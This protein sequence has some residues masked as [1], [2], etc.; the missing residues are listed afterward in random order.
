M[1]KKYQK[2][3][4]H[5]GGQRI[6]KIWGGGKPLGGGGKSLGGVRPPVYAMKMTLKSLKMVQLKKKQI[7]IPMVSIKFK[8]NFEKS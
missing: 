6:S 2:I 8:N 7:C 1:H 4:F 3:G 5:G